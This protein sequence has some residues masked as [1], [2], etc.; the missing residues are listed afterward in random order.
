MGNKCFK[1]KYEPILD[2]TYTELK[3]ITI[4]K[5]GDCDICDKKNVGGYSLNSVIEN[6]KI[7]VCKE[8]KN[9]NN[10]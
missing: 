5:I 8:C 7:F 2:L 9:L 3:Q 1:K 6:E 10:K 4:E